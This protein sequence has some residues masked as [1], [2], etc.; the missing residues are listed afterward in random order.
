MAMSAAAL[1]QLPARVVSEATGA[2]IRT[3]ERWR[4]GSGPRR[5]AYRERLDDLAAVLELLGHAM[6][7]RARQAWLV[8]RSAH[9]GWQRPVDVLAAGD[10]DRVRGAALAYAGGDPT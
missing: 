4:A 8:A 5:H 1:R 2:N 3:V 7:P 6:A 9:L 10:F